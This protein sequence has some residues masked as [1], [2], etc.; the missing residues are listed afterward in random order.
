MDECDVTLPDNTCAPENDLVVLIDLSRNDRLALPR[1]EVFRKGLVSLQHATTRLYQA[2]SGRC[3][4]STRVHLAKFGFQSPFQLTESLL[5]VPLEE[6]LSSS[7]ADEIAGGFAQLSNSSFCDRDCCFPK[8]LFDSFLALLD[9][10][11]KADFLVVIDYFTLPNSSFLNNIFN[12]LSEN[13]NK[14]R[15]LRSQEL[16]QL[17]TIRAS[18]SYCYSQSADIQEIGLSSNTYI[19][20][21]SLFGDVS[22]HK[23]TVAGLL[24]NAYC[25]EGSI[26]WWFYGQSLCEYGFRIGC[27]RPCSWRDPL[28]QP[29][30]SHKAVRDTHS[31]RQALGVEEQMI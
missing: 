28:P 15:T 25:L 6:V 10:Y 4:T 26:R 29:G 7:Q 18:D 27:D 20:D 31:I 5:A 22:P 19:V 30:P 8:T 16:V 13:G 14:V 24:C 3:S 12:R 11:P 9:E 2:K 17:F 21:S 1:L 23:F